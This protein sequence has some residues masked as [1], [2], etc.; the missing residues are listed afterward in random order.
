MGRVKLNKK[1][2]RTPEERLAQ[3]EQRSAVGYLKNLAR[4]I[5]AEK[6]DSE[7]AK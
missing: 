2:R 1:P 6:A 4:K 7:Q 5:E 3:R